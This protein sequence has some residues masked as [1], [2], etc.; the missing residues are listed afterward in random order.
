MRHGE[1]ANSISRSQTLVQQS[2]NYIYVVKNDHTFSRETDV[3][4]TSRGTRFKYDP[5]EA[6]SSASYSTEQCH[7][8]LGMEFSLIHVGKYSV[9]ISC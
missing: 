8:I 6:D 2:L 3:H 9:E 7:R 1:P 5:V 4:A